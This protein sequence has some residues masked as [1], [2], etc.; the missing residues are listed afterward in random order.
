MAYQWDD[1]KAEQEIVRKFTNYLTRKRHLAEVAEVV[2][3]TQKLKMRKRP[4][5]NMRR[6]LK[7]K[8]GRL[9]RPRQLSLREHANQTSQR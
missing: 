5:P 2:E 7:P 6:R 8:T 4:K 3:Q 9:L 1:V